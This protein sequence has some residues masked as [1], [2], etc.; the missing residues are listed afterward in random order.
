MARQG[1]CRR[2]E[3]KGRS[4]VAGPE[5]ELPLPA[6]DPFRQDETPCK[7]DRDTERVAAIQ[8]AGAAPKGGRPPAGPFTIRL[9][10]V[11]VADLFYALHQVTRRGFL[12]DGD[13][14]GRVSVDVSAATLDD[15]FQALRK[16]G[17]RLLEAHGIVRVSP[18]GALA[19]RPALVGPPSPVDATAVSDKRATFSLKREG[20]REVLAVMTEIEPALAALGPQ[21]FLGKASLWITDAPIGDVRAALLDAASLVERV[22]EG[23]RVLRRP[24]GLEDP[25]FPVAGEPPDRRLALRPEDVALLDFDFAGVATDGSGYVAFAYAPTGRLQAY[26][27]GAKLADA[28][29]RSISSTDVELDAEEGRLRL[30][31]PL[32]S[33]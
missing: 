12:V 29:V 16:S 7:I 6:E 4:P 10:D 13:V 28:T 30:A 22:E 25:V 2:L 33:K 31:L 24:A 9:R 17:L 5:A 27:P 32:P 15:V 8:Y 19:P 21:G 3:A 18:A 11:D 1:A 14:A 20:V 23:R 26:R